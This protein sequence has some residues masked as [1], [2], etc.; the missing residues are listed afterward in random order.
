MTVAER[1]RVL[2]CLFKRKHFFEWESRS[3]FTGWMVITA[4]CRN[5]KVSR[6]GR[7]I[8]V[9]EECLAVTDRYTH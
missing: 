1:L 6:A 9:T 3:R 8:R 4:T 7:P 5:C 2:V